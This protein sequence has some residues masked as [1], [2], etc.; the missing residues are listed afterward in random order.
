MRSRAVLPTH[1]EG[2]PSIAFSPDGSQLA[3]AWRNTGSVQ[4][5][6]VEARQLR[7]QLQLK[8]EEDRDDL[9]VAF[10]ADGK[11]LVVLSVDALRVWDIASQQVLAQYDVAHATSL[12]VLHERKIMALGTWDPA[13][14]IAVRLCDTRSCQPICNLAAHQLPVQAVAFASDGGALA[15]AGLDL[16]VV[17]WDL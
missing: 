11:N 13:T 17:I 12:A 2:R 6:D 4:L 1:R 7:D 16:S 5:W 9:A 3:M 8:R 10:A 15:S 14:H